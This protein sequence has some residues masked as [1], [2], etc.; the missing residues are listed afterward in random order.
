MIVKQGKHF[1]TAKIVKKVRTT[2]FVTVTILSPNF[3]LNDFASK[4]LLTRKITENFHMAKVTFLHHL[5]ALSVNIFQF[6]YLSTYNICST[7]V[8]L[9]HHVDVKTSLAL[10]YI[11]QTGQRC[12][13]EHR[14]YSPNKLKYH[15]QHEFS[16]ARRAFKRA[17]FD[18]DILILKLY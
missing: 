7:Y 5:S 3:V 16:K 4:S 2:L 17:T 10:P 12:I 9:R 8:T 13:S 14:T 18:L 6:K 15:S 11:W 1:L